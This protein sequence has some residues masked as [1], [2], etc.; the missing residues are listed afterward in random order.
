M[1]LANEQTSG[2]DCAAHRPVSPV[3]LITSI[4]MVSTASTSCSVAVRRGGIHMRI[5]CMQVYHEIYINMIMIIIT[6]INIIT[7]VIIIII[8]MITIIIMIV[9][10]IIIITDTIIIIIIITIIIT[11]A[12][13]TTYLG[14]FSECGRAFIFMT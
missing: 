1:V 7:T 13:L 10:T 12:A 3:T 4:M 14:P 2:H 9:I 11:A 5:M 8:I 6:I